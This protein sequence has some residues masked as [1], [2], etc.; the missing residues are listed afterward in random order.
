MAIF[1]DVGIGSAWRA[2]GVLAVAALAGVGCGSNTNPNPQLTFSTTDGGADARVGGGMGSGTASTTPGTSSSSTDGGRLL[3]DGGLDGLVAGTTFT[4]LFDTVFSVSC[5]GGDCHNPASRGG[6]S[7][8]TELN[9]YNSVRGFVIPGDSAHSQLFFILA[10][11]QMPPNGP[12]LTPSQL[13]MVASW[14]DA[15]A[16]NN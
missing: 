12:P 3:P 11:G 4:Q 15:G 14:I 13:A 2:V 5:G 1:A 10:N 16:L 7:F 8:F 9:G 6:V